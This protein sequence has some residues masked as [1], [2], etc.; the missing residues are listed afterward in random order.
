MWKKCKGFT[1]IELLVVIT[2]IALLVAILLPSLA[3]VQALAK[4]MTCGTN[5][6]AIGKAIATYA[7]DQSGSWPMIPNMGAVTQAL[8]LE[9]ADYAT[10]TGAKWGGDDIIWNL[11]LLQTPA[12]AASGATPQTAAAGWT[13]L[14]MIENLNLLI[15]NGYIQYRTFICPA[16][17]NSEMVRTPGVAPTGSTGRTYGFYDASG[18]PHIDY[19]YQV[20]YTFATIRGGTAAACSTDMSREPDSGLVILADAPPS[21]CAS[22]ND[23]CGMAATTF[24]AGALSPAWDRGNHKRDGV[25]MLAGYSIAWSNGK[26]NTGWN[27]NELYLMDINGSS[28]PVFNQLYTGIGGGG[29]TGGA[30][31]VPD[32]KMVP[33]SMY[34][35]VLIAPKLSAS[36]Q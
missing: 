19:A 36:F 11:G 3:R 35:S 20:G 16:S 33:D 14:N 17:G 28:T 34:D 21:I 26:T 29:T 6:T 30:A 10:G 5:L 32:Y 8:P 7:S 18:A 31:R 15:P 4:R 2:I 25:N 24:N 23:L 22:K 12:V 1:L 13:K 9:A 27:N